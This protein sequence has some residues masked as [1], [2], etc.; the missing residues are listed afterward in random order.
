MS[1]TSGNSDIRPQ[2]WSVTVAI[3]PHYIRTIDRYVDDLARK[4]AVM[5]HT[6]ATPALLRELAV[7]SKT[8]MN[9][10]EAA[11]NGH[12]HSEIIAR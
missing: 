2:D 1:T 4:N 9:L 7:L 10:A 5:V 8:V 11:L 6:R 3:D 12:E